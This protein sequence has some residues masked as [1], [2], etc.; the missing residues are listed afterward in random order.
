MVCINTTL[1]IVLIITVGGIA[2]M[3]YNCRYD[4]TPGQENMFVSGREGPGIHNPNRS[5][6]PNHSSNQG[7]IGSQ[8]YV[9][10]SMNHS[11]VD[12]YMNPGSVNH[13]VN[14]SMNPSPVDHY[15]NQDPVNHSMNKYP[16]DNFAPPGNNI[17]PLPVPPAVPIDP[18]RIYD[19]RNLSDPLAFPTARPASYIFRPM[20]NNPL[21]NIPTRGFP[22]SPA[23]VGNLVEAKMMRGGMETKFD[24]TSLL[25]LMS[26]QRYPNSNKYDY[27]VLLTSNRAPA[28]K[29][30]VKT[31][32][33]DELY[34]GDEVTIPEFGNKTYIFKKNKSAFKYNSWFI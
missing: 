28:M 10:H 26:Q 18:V 2:I 21:F 23:Y 7:H 4:K 13:S 8:Y 1:L 29:I 31:K 11:P 25:Q 34:D 20:L 5:L 22:D 19:N 16:E 32:N 17:D 27:Y 3:Y 24:D 9:D 14:H 12:H 15:M 30:K 33:H 6:N